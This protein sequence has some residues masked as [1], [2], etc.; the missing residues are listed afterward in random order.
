M[1]EIFLV[2]PVVTGAIVEDV[3]TSPS[4]HMQIGHSR[5]QHII[6]FLLSREKNGEARILWGRSPH[7]KKGD[8]NW[9]D[10]SMWRITGLALPSCDSTWWITKDRK[11]P[12]L[13]LEIVVGGG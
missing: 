6:L 9:G 11:S 2:N 3:L 10:C 12:K 8:V 13:V 5:M 7:G 1:D 4:N